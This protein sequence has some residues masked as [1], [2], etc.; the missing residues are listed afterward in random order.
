M[1][2]NKNDISCR[3]R[4]FGDKCMGLFVEKHEGV[5]G[6]VRLVKLDVCGRIQLK[7]S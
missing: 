4:E 1:K 3:T 6:R 5:G 7:L 2:E